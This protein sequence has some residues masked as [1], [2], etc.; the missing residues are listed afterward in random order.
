MSI[1]AVAGLVFLAAQ[2]P[3]TDVPVT[4]TTVTTTTVT[5]ASAPAPVSTTGPPALAPASTTSSSPAPAG[6]ALT[7]GTVRNGELLWGLKKSFRQYVGVGLG[8]ATGNSITASGGASITN[9]D[10]VVID[11]VPNPRGVP[12]GAYR[13]SFDSAD[14]TSPSRFTAKFRGTVALAYPSHFFT[15][16]ISNPQVS[17]SD[18]T[19]VLRADVELRTQ[20]GAPANP[21]ALPGVELG[22]LT[23]PAATPSGGLLT[24]PSVPVTLATSEAFAGFYQTGADLDP[25][26]MR[27]GADCADTPPPPQT[28]TVAPPP[29]SSGDDLVPEARFRPTGGTPALAATGADIEHGLWAG[30]VIVLSGLALVL[31]AYRPRTRGR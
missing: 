8:G 26:T 22:R 10:E 2:G 21:V 7:P 11:G 24:W 29:A 12:T 14:Y 1:A 3:V 19:T 16:L 9:L 6:C 17:T 31:A 15:M 5:S 18:G 30:V 27:L 25:L 28:A 23:A 13:F 4:T 20:P